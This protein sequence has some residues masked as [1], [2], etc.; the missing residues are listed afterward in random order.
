MDLRCYHCGDALRHLGTSIGRL[1]QCAACGRYLHA[2]RM[3]VYYD[4]AETSKQC[5]EDD[6][7]KVHDKVNAN[8]CDYFKPSEAAFSSTGREAEQRAQ[9]ALGALFGDSPTG[10]PVSDEKANDALDAAKALFD[11]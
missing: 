11:D 10:T 7:E 1:D 6:A 8:F 9:A 5:T 2:C 3:C 4:P